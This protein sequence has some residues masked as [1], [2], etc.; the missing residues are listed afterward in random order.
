MITN[1]ACVLRTCTLQKGHKGK[2]V[3]RKIA[4]AERTSRCAGKCR[5]QWCDGYDAGYGD[6]QDDQA[7]EDGLKR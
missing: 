3:L 2:H 1:Y 4:K 7:K 5:H 6:G